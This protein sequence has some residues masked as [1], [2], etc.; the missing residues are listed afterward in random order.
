M[1]TRVVF[2]LLCLVVLVSHGSADEKAPLVGDPNTVRGEWKSSFS[3]SPGSSDA[4]IQRSLEIGL[5]EKPES[6]RL[7]WSMYCGSSRITGGDSYVGRLIGVEEKD[8]K[9]LLVFAGENDTRYEVEFELSGNELLL[10]GSIRGVDVSDT[11]TR[12]PGCKELSRPSHP[13]IVHPS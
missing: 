7:S 11:W 12:K 10:K 9:R 1:M 2:T 4:L 6:V 8:K 3:R 5:K 13:V